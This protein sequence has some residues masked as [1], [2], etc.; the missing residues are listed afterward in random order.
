MQEITANDR[1]TAVDATGLHASSVTVHD[2]T[3]YCVLCGDTT[4]SS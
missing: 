4:L 1:N 3:D 2:V